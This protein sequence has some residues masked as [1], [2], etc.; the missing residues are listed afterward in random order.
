M[1]PPKREVRSGE[2]DRFRPRVVVVCASGWMDR[3]MVK[4]CD[5]I[6][7]NDENST[8]NRDIINVIPLQIDLKPSMFSM[9]FS[10]DGSNINI[11]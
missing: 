5:K 9:F 8:H 4:L 10:F 1:H 6:A 2:I 11:Y 7:L 3:L